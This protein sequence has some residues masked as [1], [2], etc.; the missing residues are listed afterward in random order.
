VASQFTIPQII[1][2]AQIS[3]YLSTNDKAL[4]IAFRSGS[5]IQRQPSLLYM[6]GELLENM[7]ALNPNGSTIRITAE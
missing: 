7:Y 2:F 4:S 3:Q 5:L 6:E 1:L